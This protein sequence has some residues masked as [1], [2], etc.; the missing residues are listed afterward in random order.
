MIVYGMLTCQS[1]CLVYPPSHRGSEDDD[2]GRDDEA[3]GGRQAEVVAPELQ[4]VAASS[5]PPHVVP[6]GA[7][8]VSTV[9]SPGR[10]ISRHLHS[11][12]M[13]N[14]LTIVQLLQSINILFVLY[15]KYLQNIYKQIIKKISKKT[16]FTT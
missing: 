7:E 13:I 14:I 11:Y 6:P 8:A 12:T 1:L 5:K 2:R 10:P 4:H 15:T 16:F 3:V 9:D